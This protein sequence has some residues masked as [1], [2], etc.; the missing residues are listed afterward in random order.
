VRVEADG[1]FDVLEA[2]GV[3]F[4][5]VGVGGVGHVSILVFS[6][7]IVGLVYLYCVEPRHCSR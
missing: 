4:V 3:D 1:W 6:C 5:A 2:V 7:R